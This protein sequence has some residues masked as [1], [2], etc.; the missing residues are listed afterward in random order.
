MTIGRVGDHVTD[1]TLERCE[2]CCQSTLMCEA[3]M[4]HD[5]AKCCGICTHHHQPSVLRMYGLLD[6]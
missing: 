5:T 4:D 6:R 1:P 3:C 2:G